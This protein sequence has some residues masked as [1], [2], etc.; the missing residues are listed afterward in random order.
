MAENVFLVVF[1]RITQDP[2]DTDKM[3]ADFRSQFP[4]MALAKGQDLIFNFQS[5]PN[6]KLTVKALVGNVLI[7]S[8]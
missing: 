4:V 8:P 1:S 2:Y 6:L 3:S 5:K 7:P